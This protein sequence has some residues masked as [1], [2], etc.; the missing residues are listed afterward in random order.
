MSSVWNTRPR[1][2]CHPSSFVKNFFF[3]KAVKKVA[4][5][6]PRSLELQEDPELKI[7]IRNVP[8]KTT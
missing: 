6:R 7:Q 5:Y 8:L 2:T 4:G 3:F 1:Y